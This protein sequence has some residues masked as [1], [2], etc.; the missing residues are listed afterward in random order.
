ML[1]CVE[2]FKSS[3]NVLR[4]NAAVFAGFL[5]GNLPVESRRGIN[6]NPVM[7]A[8]GMSDVNRYTYMW[9]VC[10]F[11]FVCLCVWQLSLFYMSRNNLN[12][13]VTYCATRIYLCV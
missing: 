12:G 2:Y 3:W 9:C 6:L 7:A 4:A 1:T 11:V 10:V 5:L 8:N 13:D